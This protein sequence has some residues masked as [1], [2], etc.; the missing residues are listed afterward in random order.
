M[1]GY[2]KVERMLQCTR[3]L[4][5]PSK[6]REKKELVECCL[7]ITKW[8]DVRECEGRM[9]EKKVDHH[10]GACSWFCMLNDGEM[11]EGEEGK[12]EEFYI[13]FAKN[14]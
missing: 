10:H 12:T 7:T 1:D 5:C 3:Q 11:A 8:D 2:N 9:W 4:F 6:P 14:R 13:N